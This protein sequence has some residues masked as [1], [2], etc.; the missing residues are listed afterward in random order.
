MP[1]SEVARV[2]GTLAAGATVSRLPGQV[3]SPGFV[4]PGFW[5]PGFAGE[6]GGPAVLT[7]TVSRAALEQLDAQSI[8]IGL[9]VKLD[10]EW[11]P[12]ADLAGPV[13]WRES[14]DTHRKSASLSLAGADYGV[15]ATLATWTRVPVEIWTLQ[16]DPAQ[17]DLVA[18]LEF[19][20]QV[21]PGTR[22]QGELEPVVQLE[23]DDASL[24]DQVEL[25]H[26]VPPYSGQTRG[27]IAAQLAA[28][29]G[30]T[31]TSIPDGARYDKPVFTD[32]R[33]LFEFL[34]E[35]GE[36]EGWHW[37]LA[38]RDGAPAHRLEAYTAELKRPPQPPDHLW[39]VADLLPGLTAEGPRAPASRYVVRGLAAVLV[40]EA[41]YHVAQE[42]V[43]VDGPGGPRAATHHQDA[44]GN[45][46]ET[47][48][49]NIPQALVTLAEIITTRTTR[50]GLVVQEEVLE[51]GWKNPA[52]AQYTT[53]PGDGAGPVG[54]LYYA[55][56]YI[57]DG[58]F[59]AWPRQRFLDVAKRTATTTYDS[60]DRV[61]EERS[62]EYRWERRHRAIR[63]TSSPTPAIA[64]T[65]I[66]QDDSWAF[67]GGSAIERFELALESFRRPTYDAV[68][69]VL[70]QTA[71][72]SSTWYAVGSTVDDVGL[73]YYVRY[74]GRGQ[75][76]LEA[77]FQRTEE[78]LETQY[79]ARDRRGIIGKT[80]WAKG[81]LAHE[82]PAG[83]RDWGTHRSF[84]SEEV[85]GVREQTVTRYVERADR[86]VLA[87]EVPANGPPTT[88]VLPRLPLP[89]FQ[90]SAWTRWR[91]QPV[92]VVLDDD[93]LE[94]LFGFRRE[95]VVL[96]VVQST[97][98]ARRVLRDRRR[99][100]T[101]RTVQLRR[102]ESRA[103]PGDTVLV[104]HPGHD[105][106]HRLLLVERQVTRD[107]SIPAST[108]TY[109]LEVPL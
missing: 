109:T 9:R 60:S 45:V 58:V 41:G 23:A 8:S 51:R 96:D 11:V 99:R 14:L 65:A 21:I 83:D 81:W 68:T 48:E 70:R 26:E 27:A 20:G 72:E 67:A 33:P 87:V 94:E 108:A 25:C 5:G 105:L 61:T 84:R 6:G 88:T 36:P 56:A 12:A 52:A 59:V 46:T 42:R 91:Q 63:P 107:L 49:P 39:T 77:T 101:A 40:D 89:D 95:V 86:T 16:G 2:R 47:G 100:A 1:F 57:D 90:L 31:V 50:H 43:R 35:W 69:G 44:A 80:V 71:G 106:A 76:D 53:G 75:V 64:N 37:R 30:L 34:R 28:D 32:Q 17:G 79:L 74:D 15:F 102:P 10:G 29:V 104:V 54:G 22:Q 18:E 78:T 97:E 24:Y 4:A 66:A 55:D 13:S 98:E 92:E 103:R 93:V 82:A 3:A 62:R 85:F 73:G 38:P 7:G 19:R